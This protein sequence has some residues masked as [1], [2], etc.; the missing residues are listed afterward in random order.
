[1]SEDLSAR[2]QTC[3]VKQRHSQKEIDPKSGVPIWGNLGKNN[4]HKKLAITVPKID[5]MNKAQAP[6]PTTKAKTLIYNQ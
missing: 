2:S 4:E 3:P 5:K 6:S 1:M